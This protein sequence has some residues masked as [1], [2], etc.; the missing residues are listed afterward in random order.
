MPAHHRTIV[1]CIQL[2]PSDRREPR[3]PCGLS[4]QNV[5]TTIHVSELHTSIHIF[6][7]VLT[8]PNK[9]NNIRFEFFQEKIIFG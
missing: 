9:E 4:I 6:C 8:I 3:M 1:Q 2:C 5:V 7:I